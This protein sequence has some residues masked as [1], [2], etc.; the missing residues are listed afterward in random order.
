MGSSK[1]RSS[2]A[3]FTEGTVRN[4]VHTLVPQK[5]VRSFCLLRNHSRKTHNFRIYDLPRVCSGCQVKSFQLGLFSKS[6]SNREKLVLKKLFSLPFGQARDLMAKRKS[7]L[8]GEFM[9]DY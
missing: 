3:E 2:Y 7:D 8:I 9:Q 6:K 4:L 5:Y 1:A